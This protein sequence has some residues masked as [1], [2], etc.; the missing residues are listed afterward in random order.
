MLKLAFLCDWRRLINAAITASLL[1]S[2]RHNDCLYNGILDG[3]RKKWRS[4]SSEG[5]LARNDFE[6]DV[7]NRVDFLQWEQMCCEEWRSGYSKKST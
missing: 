1:A 7:Y 3:L 6:K 2:F 5:H 4:F